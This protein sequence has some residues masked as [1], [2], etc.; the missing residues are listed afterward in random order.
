VA[1]DFAARFGRRLHSFYG[2]SETGGIAYDRGGR[3]A[4]EGGVGQANIRLP[5][6]IGVIAEASGGIGSIRTYGLKQDGD[7]Y[8]NEAYGKSPATIRLK[9]TGGIGEIVLNQEP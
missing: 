2:S 4:L 1:R 5:K 9:V 6:K 8:T 7:S 3:A